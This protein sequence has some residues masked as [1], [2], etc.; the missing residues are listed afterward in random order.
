MPLSARHGAALRRT[1]VFWFLCVF[2]D[3]LFFCSCV[4]YK[5]PSSVLRQA[6]F[7]AA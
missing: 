6:A 3:T 1:F 7:S 2:L 5:Y 4:V